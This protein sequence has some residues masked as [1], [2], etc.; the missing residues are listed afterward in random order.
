MQSVSVGFTAASAA[1]NQQPRSYLEIM[2]S[3]YP[4][5]LT[6][7]GSA[8]WT[9]ESA[10][11]VRHRG[12]LRI[13]PPGENMVPAGSV[14]SCDIALDNT[15]QRF[16]W[17][18]PESELTAY[19]S[20]P[21][22]PSGRPVRVWQGFDVGGITEYVCIFTGIID[23]WTPDTGGGT[24]DLHCK[25]W[26]YRWL[27][28]KRSTPLATKKLPSEWVAQ[29]CALAGLSPV[30]Q[31]VGIFHIPFCWM[32]DESVVDEIWQTW[33]ADGGVCYFDQLG[34]LRCENAL[35]WL[36]A[37]HDTIQWT[38]DE[39]TYRDVDPQNDLAPVATKITV[40]W[41]GRAIGSA[42]QLYEL[43]QMKVLMPGRSETWVARFQYG[44]SS[45][46]AP[47]PN[48]PFNDYW[49]ETAG[50]KPISDKIS[51]SIDPAK[52]YAQQ[53]T[54]TVTNVSTSLAARLTYMQLR[55]YPLIGGPTEQEEALVVPAP[56]EYDRVRQVRGNPYLQRSAQGRA[57]G[58]LLAVRG[59]RIR[60]LW[61]L[62]DVAGIPQLELGD[63]VGFKNSKLL[64]TTTGVGIV[65]GIQ[66]DGGPTAG[67]TQQVGVLDMTDFTE[68]SRYFIIGRD[69]LGAY[70][71]IYY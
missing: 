57:L 25:D 29:I 1:N 34:Q 39:G 66:W 30:I 33:E 59:Q 52:A 15:T 50:G 22:G 61:Q 18:N 54:L 55:G 21:V 42:I 3:G 4:S 41:A 47:N 63:R 8:G 13:E 53:C 69:T 68:Y 24:V 37:P 38:F 12:T 67:F 26:G 17:Q 14:G 10:Y 9:N 40:E 43:D 44:C 31:D 58:S 60:P 71:R 56:F 70:Q 65:T 19:I 64:G 20:G 46:I 36:S 28:Q 35:H 45:V 23:T 62:M 49:A 48:D 16:E 7:R 27:Q 11:L 2:W 5:G 6:A 32:D 51:I